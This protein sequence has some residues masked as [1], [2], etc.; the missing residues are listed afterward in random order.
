MTRDI[1]NQATVFYDHTTT[2]YYCVP[3]YA[4][5]AVKYLQRHGSAT[6]VEIEK[7]VDMVLRK[8]RNILNTLCDAGVL[9]KELEQAE[10]EVG[11]R[12]YRYSVAGDLLTTLRCISVNSRGKD[13]IKLAS[14]SSSL[15]KLVVGQYDAVDYA[16]LSP[17]VAK[18]FT[19]VQQQ[20]GISH[21][22]LT[23]ISEL[24]RFDIHTAVKSLIQ[25]NLIYKDLNGCYR[26]QKHYGK[27]FNESLNVLVI[28]S[29][30]ELPEQL[31]PVLK[32]A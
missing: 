29:T 5:N 30:T 13:S 32:A 12:A 28:N 7:E 14:E 10:R 3:L 25:A 19:T 31:T 24:S 1:R 21:G 16:I 17:A 6:L 20:P 4:L 27:V 26:V 2:R 9:N 23:R 18:T 22:A 11:R 8:L 15:F